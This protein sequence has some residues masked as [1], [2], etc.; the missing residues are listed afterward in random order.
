M[1]YNR[2]IPIIAFGLIPCVF[3]Q[4]KDLRILA[5][6][7]FH[8]QISEGQKIGD[9]PVG[10]AAVLASYLK[11]EIA[12]NE[13]QTF[14]V[15]AGDLVGASEPASSLLQDE[16]AVMFFNYLGNG[17]WSTN[18]RLEPLNNLVG[19]LGNHEFDRGK[20]ELFRLL[21]GGNFS[22]GPFLENPWKGARF[23][24]I[25]ANALI[26]ETGT[27][28][29]SPFVIKKIK[30]SSIQIAFIGAILKETPSMV[31]ANSVK[32]LLFV[33]EARAIN[34]QVRMLRENLG[35]HVF[36]V[37][38][39]QGD[40]QTFYNGPTDSTKEIP[41]RVL[42]NIVLKLDDD[43]DVVCSAHA[44]CFTNALVPNKNSAKILVT[45]AFAKGTAYARIDL[46]IDTLTQDV[47][48]KSARIITTYAD[49]GPGL[50]PDSAVGVFVKRA[51]NIVAPLTSRIIGKTAHAIMARQNSAGESALGDLI[52]DA[53]RLAMS[54]D[55]AFTNPG[56]IRSNLDS[57]AA[58]WGKLYTIQPFGNYCVSMNLTGQ[59]MF[60][61]LNQQWADSLNPKMLQISGFTYTWDNALPKNGRIIE[62]R[63]NGLPIKKNTKYSIT[64]NSFL[65]SG[66]DDF[67]AF[68]NGT[69]RVTGAR[70]LD[71]LVNYIAKLP[72]PINAI[73]EGRIVRRN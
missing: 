22:K 19:C 9:R 46:K 38:L 13:D 65:S 29:V 26:E 30:N 37:L 52:A 31:S 14:I 11:S 49:N 10:G 50:A 69:L 57:G 51:E 73:I 24:V 70:D 5:I 20:D 1:A 6:N 56:G 32:G 27:Y 35:I 7:D 21:Y 28:L 12:S 64:V 43:V 23:P 68:K 66:G 54:T 61:V 45:Q 16:P 15:E 67:V 72:Q 42:K 47:I 39:H 58:T 55:F 33:D 18:N 17:S 59:Q 60:D 25:C 44:H 62:I 34:Q 8:G 63:K 40:C 48:S 71:V 3:A 41:D 36:I 53:Q 4:Y 2:V